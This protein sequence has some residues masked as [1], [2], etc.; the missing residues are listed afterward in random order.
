MMHGFSITMGGLQ[1]FKCSSEEM[2]KNGQRI[3]W[4]DD[5]PLHPL[6]GSDLVQ[7]N[8]HESFTMPTTAEI[9]DRGKSN[10]LTK[11]LVLLQMS[12]FVMQCFACMR[13]RVRKLMILGSEYMS[14]YTMSSYCVIVLG[15]Y[16]IETIIINEWN[17]GAC[18]FVNSEMNCALCR[19]SKCWAT[20]VATVGTLRPWHYPTLPLQAEWRPSAVAKCLA[21]I[22]RSALVR[23]S[24]IISSV[25]Q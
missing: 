15:R 13:S 5:K 16:I 20:H 11:S 12:W 25:E 21:L 23:V 3:L 6:G 24:A 9:K 4:E 7:C 8:I 17:I 10:W 19:R 18:T 22:L 1:I 14:I 2:S